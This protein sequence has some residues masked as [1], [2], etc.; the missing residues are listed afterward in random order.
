MAMEKHYPPHIIG[1]SRWTKSKMTKGDLIL[2]KNR[3]TGNEV[4]KKML[5]PS[6]HNV[7]PKIR[8]T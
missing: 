6:L 3:Q 4:E 7:V 2:V 1:E 5:P 8:V